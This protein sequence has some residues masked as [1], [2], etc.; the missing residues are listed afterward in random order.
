M[1]CNDWADGAGQRRRWPMAKQ[2]VLF[3][4]SFDP[5]HFGHLITARAVAEQCDFS[6][7]TLVPA[8]RA[9]HKCDVSASAADRLAMLRLAI[10]GEDLFDICEAE[11]LRTGASYTFDTLSALRADHGD[12]VPL[13]WVIGADMLADLPNWHRASEV[14]ELTQIV[15]ACRPPWHERMDG[16]LAELSAVFGIEAADRLGRAVVQSPL[17]DISSSAIRNRVARGLS[18]R[19]LVPEDV[20]RYISSHRL[21]GER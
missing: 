4:G 16:I 12:Q 17:I 8:A 2:M 9:P 20:R 15:V 7:V 21:Y 14:I 5:I 1:W 6:R 11:L 3:G 18:I 13:H 10:E 19:Y